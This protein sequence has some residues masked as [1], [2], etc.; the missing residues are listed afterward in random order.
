MIT[1]IYQDANWP[2]FTWDLSKIS[3]PLS[4]IRYRQGRLLGNMEALGFDLRS[5]TMLESLSLNLIK[6]SE[7]EGELLNKDQ[8]RSSIAKRLGIN[9]PNWVAPS[10]NIDALVDMMLDATQ[11]YTSPLTADRLFAWQASLFPTGRSGLYK[12]K[13]G[14]WRDDSKGPMQV[15]SG[16]YGK[17]KI[18]YEAPVASTLEQEISL[19]LKWF[20]GNDN[21]DPVLKAAIAHLWFVTIHPF[22]DGNGRIARTIADM[23]LARADD[24]AQR[25]YSMSAQIL[26]ERNQYYDVLEATQKGSLDITNWILWFL[27]CLSRSL[28]A[29]EIHI[30]KVMAKANFW[31]RA[32]SL[33]L[34]ERQRNMINKLLDDFEGKLTTSKWAKLTKC[35]HDTAMR[36]IQH[37]LLNNILLKEEGGGRSTS[38]C[39]RVGVG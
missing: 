13:I 17:Q 38:Y 24:S 15:I 29:T 37:L 23:Q 18:H 11:A 25:F 10:H 31:E 36:D 4:A 30:S 8:V 16:G 14:A 32:A 34:N 5:K 26:R 2:N 35:S 22:E 3:T 20:N 39:L 6:S 27:E 7:I 28:D 21:L 19:F 9:I 12:I 1:Y 33:Q